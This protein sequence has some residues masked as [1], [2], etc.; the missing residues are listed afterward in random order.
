MVS[1]GVRRKSVSRLTED[2]AIAARI[3]LIALTSAAVIAPSCPEL[4]LS[5]LQALT[6]AGYHTPHL[7]RRRPMSLMRR[8]RVAFTLLLC[9]SVLS[10]CVTLPVPIQIPPGWF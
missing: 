9:S 8:I 3:T 2:F 6:Q 10:S 5:L 4:A 1:H 7:V